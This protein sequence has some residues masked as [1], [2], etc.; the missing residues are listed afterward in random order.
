MKDGAQL[1]EQLVADEAHLAGSVRYLFDF[2]VKTLNLNPGQADFIKRG[3]ETLELT[4]ND[5]LEDWNK[6]F[7]YILDELRQK[8]VQLEQR[9]ALLHRMRRDGRTLLYRREVGEERLL[10]TLWDE[11][12]G[13]G[14]GIELADH[15]HFKEYND[16]YGHAVG[17][18][19]LST[20]GRLFRSHRGGDIGV[21]WG[22][23]EYLRIVLDLVTPTQLGILAARDV[24]RV[25]TYGWTELDSCFTEHPPRLSVGLVYC[26]LPSVEERARMKNLDAEVRLTPEQRFDP[27][28]RVPPGSSYELG[29]KLA[30]L[31]DTMMYEVKSARHSGPN[32]RLAQVNVRIV[33]GELVEM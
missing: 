26:E 28:V 5:K 3:F 21:R 24:E 32:E 10:F 18:L 14:F 1:P 7:V 27:A 20:T 22:G 11:R 12:R 19:V 29:R 6:V 4:I 30:A 23:D 8:G 9:D 33:D 15:D 17:D 2:V 25:E 31:A 13:S 16:T